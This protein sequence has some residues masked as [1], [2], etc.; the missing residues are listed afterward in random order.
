MRVARSADENLV[1]TVARCVRA[2][3]IGTFANGTLDRVDTRV[4]T[5]T[6]DITPAPTAAAPEPTAPAPAPAAAPTRQAFKRATR[7]LPAARVTPRRVIVAVAV[8]LLGLYVCR[9]A[10]KEIFLDYAWPNEDYSHI[11]FAPLVAGLLVYVRRLRLRHYQ[12]GGTLLGPLIVGTGLSM[13]FAGFQTSRQFLFHSGAVFVAVGCVVSVLGKG[14][15]F[16]FGPAVV[17][18]AFMVP[19]PGKMRYEVAAFLQHWT[20]QIAHVLLGAMGFATE[21]LGNTVSVQVATDAAGTGMTI[22][23]RPVTIAEACNG[24]RSVFMLLL[25][26]YAFAF[27][28]PLRNGVRALLLLASPLVALVCNIIRTLPTILFYGYAP[29]WFDDPARGTAVADHFHWIAG[30]AMYVVAFLIWLGIVAVL[31]WTMLPIQRYTLAS[32]SG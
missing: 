18:L 22:Q 32:Q 16:R 28:L 8:L 21:V 19:F 27:A 17:A 6:I 30:Y 24:M 11:F 13:M 9:D 26:A 15:L 7:A 14:V 10:W 4:S 2:R 31:R 1:G 29:D 5:T 25:L 3:V 23:Q 20:A 12:V